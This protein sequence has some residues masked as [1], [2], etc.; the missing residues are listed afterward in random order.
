MKISGRWTKIND[1]RVRHVWTQKCEC[2]LEDPVCYIDPDFYE[3]N[4]TP[5]CEECGDDFKYVRTDIKCSSLG[6]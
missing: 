3:N 5:I 2:K 6:V 1:A 4:G